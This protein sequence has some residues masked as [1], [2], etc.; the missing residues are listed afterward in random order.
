MHPEL[1]DILP[2]RPGRGGPLTLQAYAEGPEVLSGALVAADG[3]RFAIRDGVPRMVPQQDSSVTID[4][5]ATQR[6]RLRLEAM[7]ARP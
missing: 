1:L 7:G 3:T 6:R 5:G 4:E 2:H